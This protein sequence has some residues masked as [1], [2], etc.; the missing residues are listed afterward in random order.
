MKYD[1]ERVLFLLTQEKT[2]D[3]LNELVQLNYGLLYKQ[4]KKFYLINDPDAISLGYEALYKAI[5]TFT[6]GKSAFSTYATVCIYN[7]LGCH[8]RSLNTKIATNTGSYEEVAFEDLRLIDTLEAP[9]SVDEN[10]LSEAGIEYFHKVFE[11]CLK[12]LVRSELH[13][14]IISLWYESNF[15]M[16]HARIAEELGCA[17]SYVSQTIKWFKASMKQIWEAG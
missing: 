14:Q 11:Y 2:A 5:L 10:I 4:L 8:V 17:Q 9:G 15:T 12:E 3:V 6:P 16:T 13:K 1:K 7:Q